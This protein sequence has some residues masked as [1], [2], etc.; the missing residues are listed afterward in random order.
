MCVCVTYIFSIT[1]DKDTQKNNSIIWFLFYCNLY[2]VIVTIKN[3]FRRPLKT[4]IHKHTK[5]VYNLTEKW[6]ALTKHPS[7]QGDK[8]I[9]D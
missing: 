3:I 2:F 8:F 7:Y 4:R 1:N 6:T 5:D 9:F